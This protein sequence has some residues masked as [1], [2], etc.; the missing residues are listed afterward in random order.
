[1]QKMQVDKQ[2]SKEVWRTIKVSASK[3]SGYGI[4][5]RPNREDLV[6][7]PEVW[8]WDSIYLAQDVYK[9]DL[10]IWHIHPIFF[11]S[12]QPETGSAIY[13][14]CLKCLI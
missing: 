8:G 3:E 9:V 7:K 2:A 14:A 10:Y 1:M 4:L 6:S 13:P 12:P 5:T 11:L